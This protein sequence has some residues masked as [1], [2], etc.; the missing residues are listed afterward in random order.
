MR[1][2]SSSKPKAGSRRW[3]PRPAPWRSDSSP[4]PMVAALG[5][6][7]AITGRGYSKR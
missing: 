2:S 7:S 6:P 3:P 1:A 4:R 5:P